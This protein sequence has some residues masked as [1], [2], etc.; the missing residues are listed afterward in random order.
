MDLRGTAGRT[1]GRGAVVL[2]AF[3][4]ALERVLPHEE[5][6]DYVAVARRWSPLR[7]RVRRPCRDGKGGAFIL[8][9]Y[10]RKVRAMIADHIEGPEIDQVI[11]P[12]SLTALTFDDAVRRP[13]PREAAAAGLDSPWRGSPAAVTP[14]QIDSTHS[15]WSTNGLRFFW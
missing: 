3:L 15:G 5:A 11:P 9:R 14:Y 4:V 1:E 6:L 8:R 7:K 12:V 2:H 10:G 13:P